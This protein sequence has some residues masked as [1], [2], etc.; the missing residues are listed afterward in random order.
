MQRQ[1]HRRR[2]SGSSH[3]DEESIPRTEGTSG[4]ASTSTILS[5]LVSTIPLILYGLLIIGIGTHLPMPRAGMPLLDVDPADA[6][7]VSLSTLFEFSSFF[8]YYLILLLCRCLFLLL[9]LGILLR[10]MY[11][12]IL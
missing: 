7:H 6:T 11:M 2:R 4:V 9:S 10:S 12:S 3:F 8:I 5:D 1:G